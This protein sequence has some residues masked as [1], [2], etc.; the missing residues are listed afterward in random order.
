MTATTRRLGA[1]LAAAAAL[2]VWASLHVAYAADGDLDFNFGGGDGLVTTNFNNTT[3]EARAVAIQPDGKIVTVGTTHVSENDYD[4]SVARYNSDG[5]PDTTFGGGDGRVT[6]NIG[7]NYIDVAEDVAIQPDGKILAVGHY[8]GNDFVA[9]RYNPDGSLDDSFGG[10]GIV[11]HGISLADNGFAVAIQDDGK[12]VMAGHTHTISSSNVNFCVMRMHP[13]GSLDNSFDGDGILTTDFF[14]NTDEAHAVA[15]QAGKIVVAGFAQVNGFNY[16]FALA[17]YNP[18]GSLDNSFGGG[19]GKATTDFFGG[20]DGALSMVLQPDGKIVAAGAFYSAGQG[21]DFGLVRY[22]FNGD[23]DTSFDNDGLQAVNFVGGTATEVAYGVTR[24][25]Y[26]GKIVAVGY[27][28]V[29]GVN[30]F[31]LVRLNLNGSL[32]GSFGVGGKVNHDFGGGVALGYGVAVQADGKIVAAGTAYMGE[33]NS[34]DYALARYLSGNISNPTSTPAPNV[35]PTSCPI[36]FSDVPPGSTFYDYVRCLA[37]RDIVSGYSDAT[38]RPGNPVTRGQ[39]AKI[40]SSSAGYSEPHT[41]QTFEDVL[42]GS[43]F[44]LF[45]ERLYTR[46]HISGYACGGAGE[47][48]VPPANR[49]YFR[50]GANVTR[51]Q[52]AKIVASAAGL[53]APPPGLWTFQDVPQGSTFWQW[54]EELSSSGAISGYPCGGDGEPCVPPENRYYFRPGNNVTRG[55]SAKIVANTFFPG[56]Q[57]PGSVRK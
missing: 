5:S 52:T 20:D 16:D 8:A 53:P 25:P 54:V 30:D 38:F 13:D 21:Y 2:F 33:P 42:V 41:N 11:G 40:V 4:F 57:T 55:Q 26:D 45:I 49:P 7:G 36:Q 44:Y 34:Y 28:P 35:T 3:D 24:Q 51:G 9:V 46:G 43:T 47:P 56:C 31:A 27:A 39:L 15:I 14:G 37:C 12:I 48:C 19:D 50:P 17:R 29:G 1:A 23:L 22:L 10:D 32:D 18:N 6:T